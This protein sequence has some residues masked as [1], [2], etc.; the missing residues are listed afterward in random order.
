MLTLNILHNLLIKSRVHVLKFC[1]CDGDNKLRRL[2]SKL[3]VPIT[4]E[5]R[6]KVL[7][8]RNACSLEAAQEERPSRNLL[9]VYY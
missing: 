5:L 3:L 1:K 9:S 4:G 8:I 7:K 2:V 6:Y